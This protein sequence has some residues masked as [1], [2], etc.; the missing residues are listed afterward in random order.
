MMTKPI[1]LDDE[2]L[3]FYQ[4]CSE[5]AGVTLEEWLESASNGEF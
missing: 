1:V 3:A 5:L 4:E 2:T